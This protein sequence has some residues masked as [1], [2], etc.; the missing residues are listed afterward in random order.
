MSGTGTPAPPAAPEALDEARYATLV[1]EAFIAERGTPFLLSPK[2]W[3]LIR[4]WWERNLPVATVVR[5]IHETFERRRARGSLGKI[6]SV[7]YCENAVE[8]AWEL[9][10]HGLVGKRDPEREPQ[11][12]DLARTLASLADGVAARRG[13]RLDG[14]DP[15]AAEKAI[16]RAAAKLRAVE[17][18]GGFDAAEERLAEIEHALAKA[19]LGAL[20]DEVRT[21]LEAR[22]DRLLGDEAGVPAEVRERTRRALLRREVRRAFDLPPL[23]LLDA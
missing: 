4:G 15:S 11:P 3:R 18:S 9:E 7:A 22:A 17:T 2:D 6:S 14:A 12:E 16:D 8:E 23:T 19:L 20:S 13:A 10:R 1:E 5:A 21:A